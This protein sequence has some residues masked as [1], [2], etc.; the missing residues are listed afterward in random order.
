MSNPTT[1]IL[2]MADVHCLAI[3]KLID[4]GCADTSDQLLNPSHL[5][6]SLC[7]SP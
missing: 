3:D 2:K 1:E 4:S 6:A 7:E 5:A